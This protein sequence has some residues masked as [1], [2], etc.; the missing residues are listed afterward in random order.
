MKR[1]MMPRRSSW[2]DGPA[3]PWRR[4]A[5]RTAARWDLFSFRGPKSEVK[6]SEK[7]GVSEWLRGR[8]GNLDV[9]RPGTQSREQGRDELRVDVGGLGTA[10]VLPLVFVHGSRAR[11]GGRVLRSHR[12]SRP[13]ERGRWLRQ[14]VRRRR[15]LARGSTSIGSMSSIPADMGGAELAGLAGYPYLH[16]RLRYL[17]GCSLARQPARTFA[18]RRLMTSDSMPRRPCAEWF[19][20][21]GHS[22]DTL[23]KDATILSF[24]NATRDVTTATTMGCSYDGKTRGTYGK[25]TSLQGQA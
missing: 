24:R 5:G 23:D 22:S 4:A 9:V 10:A 18:P 14:D 20:P 15:R 19:R 8:S 17:Q 12:L 6:R 2:G 1:W 13:S 11:G 25:R 3:W 7:G 16:V 21:D